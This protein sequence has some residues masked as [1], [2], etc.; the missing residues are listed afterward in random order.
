M[1]KLLAWLHSGAASRKHVPSGAVPEA[2]T[3]GAGTSA[4]RGS[5]QTMPSVPIS[6]RHAQ[7]SA[8][9]LPPRNALPEM[10]RDAGRP[11]ASSPHAG[12][13]LHDFPDDAAM[14]L[15]DQGIE[16]LLKG[17][18]DDGWIS[19]ET[20][21]VEDAGPRPGRSDTMN[22]WSR[23]HT[24]TREPRPPSLATIRERPA[25]ELAPPGGMTLREALRRE[26]V[27]DAEERRQR[28]REEN[29]QPPVPHSG[30]ARLRPMASPT[31]AHSPG[32]RTPMDGSEASSRTDWHSFAT[33][34]EYEDARTSQSLASLHPEA[35]PPSLASTASYHDAMASLQDTGNP[36]DAGT[37]AG[38][39]APRLPS[40]ARTA[41]SPE[42]DHSTM[43]DRWL[44]EPMPPRDHLLTRLRLQEKRD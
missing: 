7:G 21:E 40:G 13:G 23:G 14:D 17:L 35:T 11:I 41:A 39:P 44:T 28:L 37:E 1:T 36:T 27:E 34:T 32:T 16:N 6:A 5:R 29:P 25:D 30:Y 20:H 18:R 38:Q 2:S 3:S 22:P 12:A 33:S 15:S 31:P 10:P 8:S 19:A 42:S 43:L 24:G 9:G 4:H 26:K